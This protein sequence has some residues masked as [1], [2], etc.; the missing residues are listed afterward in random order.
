MWLTFR[1]G[2]DRGKTVE[3]NGSPITLGR[4][5][6]CDLVLAD[7]RVSRRH[8]TLEPAGDGRV[9]LRDLGSGNG[10]YVNGERVEAKL[11]RGDEQLQLGDTVLVTSREQPRAAGGETLLGKGS[12]RRGQSS[13]YRLVMRRSRRATILSSG[14][15]AIAIVV[16]AL[17]ATGVLPGGGGGS[18]GGSAAVERV[19]S[20]AAPATV[21]IEGRRAGRAPIDGSGWVLD[22]RAGLIVTNAHVVNDAESFS[23]GP[24]GRLRPARVIAAAPCEDLAVLKLADPSGLKAMPLGSQ[25]SLRL[26]ETVV[27]L[28]YPQTASRKASLTSTTG[29]VSVARSVYREPA[30]DI[31]LYPNVVQT[32]AA[33]NP[34]NSGG[35]LLDLRGR[36]VGVNSAGRTVSQSGRIVQGQNYAIGVD[37]VKQV[38]RTLRAGRSIG[39]TGAGFDYPSPRSGAGDGLKIGRAVDGTAAAAAASG[40]T[41]STITA[42]DGRAVGNALSSY[43]DAVAG[44]PSGRRITLTVRDPSSAATRTVKLTL[45]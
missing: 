43:C 13:I 14:A 2:S 36:L 32:D 16:A 19:V 45:E 11:L 37:R 5:E 30:L 34:G 31:P 41:G 3:I 7:A 6:A 23:A 29:V 42:I 9:S 22:A 17:F 35:P 24:G 44:I 33:I 4:D 38:V 12:Q 20:T 21:L 28:G 15:A 40:L 1:S 18:D 10:T 8:A 39:W 26:G 25:S 27:A